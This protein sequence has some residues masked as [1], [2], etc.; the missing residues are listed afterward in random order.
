MK[1]TKLNT[2]ITDRL[3]KIMMTDRLTLDSDAV[4]MLR[5]DLS[6]ALGSYFEYDKDNLK[7]DLYLDDNAKYRLDV[8]LVADAI[9][10]IKSIK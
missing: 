2:A 7:L 4:N 9:I 5:A 3:K 1:N 8:T 10:P 6:R